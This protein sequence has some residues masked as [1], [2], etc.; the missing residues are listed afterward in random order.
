MTFAVSGDQLPSIYRT[1]CTKSSRIQFKN[2]LH[3]LVQKIILLCDTQ[4]VQE[5]FLE[6]QSLF[7]ILFKATDLGF[8]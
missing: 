4:H 3:F 7:S 1:T 5:K 2:C 8:I 6:I